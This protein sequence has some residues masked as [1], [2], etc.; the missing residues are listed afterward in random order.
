MGDDWEHFRRDWRSQRR[1]IQLGTDQLV[2][3]SHRL[4]LRCFLVA[5][6]DGEKLFCS[7]NNLDRIE[8]HV[9]RLAQPWREFFIRSERVTAKRIVA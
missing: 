2:K 8:S 3:M 6:F 1:D 9:S 7:K 5:N 4:D